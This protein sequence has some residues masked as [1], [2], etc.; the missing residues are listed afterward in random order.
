MVAAF[1]ELVR[2][3]DDN[4]GP[5]WAARYATRTY[6]VNHGFS[7]QPDNLLGFGAAADFVEEILQ[8][9]HVAPRLLVFR[10]LGGH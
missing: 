7:L 1:A 3:L 2:G 5:R 10:R 6:G 4:D 9:D 8:E